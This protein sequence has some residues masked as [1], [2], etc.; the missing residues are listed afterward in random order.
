ME[1]FKEPVRFFERRRVVTGEDIEVVVDV[2]G[3]RRFNF[4]CLLFASYY[5]NVIP[6]KGLTSRGHVSLGHQVDALKSFASPT[7]H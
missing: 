7:S 2:E 6:V 3:E 4:L 1:T 5:E